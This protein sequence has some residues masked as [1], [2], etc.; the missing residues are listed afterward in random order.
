MR[1]FITKGIYIYKPRK[2]YM[3]Q[4]RHKSLFFAFPV[5]H[6]ICVIFCQTCIFQITNFT[7]FHVQHYIEFI[8][9]YENATWST[10]ITSVIF[11]K[12]PAITEH[13]IGKCMK[14]QFVPL[15]G[16]EL[17]YG[18][19]HGRRISNDTKFVQSVTWVIIHHTRCQ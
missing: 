15:N 5:Q 13:N 8:F 10:S 11:Y 16:Y 9:L 19:H 17:N 18:T 3:Y 2:M 6:S 14:I 1:Y 12:C 7:M 4:L